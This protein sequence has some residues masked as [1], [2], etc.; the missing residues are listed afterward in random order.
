MTHTN[1]FLRGMF[2]AYMGCEV[3]YTNISDYSKRIKL[4]G[5]YDTLLICGVY[6]T[7][8]HN[9]NYNL[10][11][12]DITRCKPIL[13]P[14][15]EVKDDDAVEVGR[16]VSGNNPEFDDTQNAVI[17]KMVAFALAY[18]AGVDFPINYVLHCIDYLRSPFRQ[19]GTPK[20]VYDCGYM[21]IPSLITAGLAISSTTTK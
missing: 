6:Q 20:P 7:Q 19:D 1:E 16:T 9:S 5:F 17:G 4:F 14:L 12:V 11:T 13:T 18:G 2:A 15:S 21:H 3:M 10:E 8:V